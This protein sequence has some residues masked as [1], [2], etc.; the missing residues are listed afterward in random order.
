MK[1]LWPITIALVTALLTFLMLAYLWYYVCPTS[2]PTD[3]VTACQA[4]DINFVRWPVVTLFLT[5]IFIEITSLTIPITTYLNYRFAR[6]TWGATDRFRVLRQGVWVGGFVTLS[7][8]LQLTR[9][10][11][12]TVAIVLLTI[13][14]LLELF[15]LNR[16]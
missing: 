3:A 11:N 14:V 10:L 9:V 7:A 15:I 13:F 6:P 2:A 12:W 1:Q 5:L 8:Y 16:D 4:Q